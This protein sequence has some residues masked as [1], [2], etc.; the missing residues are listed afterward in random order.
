[1]IWTPTTKGN[2]R[3][4]ALADRHYTR[5]KPGSP[6]W[7]RPGYSAVLYASTDVGEA[8]FVW[9]RPKWEDG[10]PGTSRKDGLRCI[11]CTHFRREGVAFDGGGAARGV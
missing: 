4:R 11:E 7:T 8:V 1:M 6:Q 9:W 5:Q 3:C 2:A 10:R